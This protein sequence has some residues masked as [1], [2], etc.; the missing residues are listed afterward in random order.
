MSCPVL[1][2]PSRYRPEEAEEVED[3]E[4]ERG[5]SFKKI[6]KKYSHGP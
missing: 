4:D 3:D 6:F 2:D 5:E 1:D